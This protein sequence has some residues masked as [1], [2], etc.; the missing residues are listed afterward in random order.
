MGRVKGWVCKSC[1]LR[2]AQYFLGN[3][4]WRAFAKIREFFF[5]S[6]SALRGSQRVQIR[7]GAVA[8]VGERAIKNKNP[9]LDHSD[10]FIA[11][12]AQPLVRRP[13]ALHRHATSAR[14][15]YC[16]HASSTSPYEP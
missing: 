11:S 16:R 8:C 13:F 14:S 4:R 5:I 15:Q 1:A 2:L 9:Q 10:R 3:R 6:S 12:L 7:R